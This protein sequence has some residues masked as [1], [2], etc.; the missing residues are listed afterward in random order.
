MIK[1][2]RQAGE[3]ECVQLQEICERHHASKEF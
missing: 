1:V 2:R 3:L